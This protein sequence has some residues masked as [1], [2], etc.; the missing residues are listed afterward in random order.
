MSASETSSSQRQSLREWSTVVLEGPSNHDEERLKLMSVDDEK[1]S[2]G[3]AVEEKSGGSIIAGIS[4]EPFVAITVPHFL[5]NS[6]VERT[7]L[8]K[9]EYPRRLVVEETESS[10]Y[11]R[12][13]T[14]ESSAKTLTSLLSHTDNMLTTII[15][16]YSLS[17]D[18]FPSYNKGNEVGVNMLEEH[19]SSDAENAT[20]LSSKLSSSS[21]GFYKCESVSDEEVQPAFPSSQLSGAYPQSNGTDNAESSLER[22]KIQL[23]LKDDSRIHGVDAMQ[24]LR[25]DYEEDYE[26][27]YSPRKLQLKEEEH[28]RTSDD[29]GIVDTENQSKKAIILKCPELSQIRDAIEHSISTT[30]NSTITQALKKLAENAPEHTSL[31]NLIT[32]KAE[33]SLSTLQPSNDFTSQETQASSS[34]S[35]QLHNNCSSAT[36]S[37]MSKESA[38]LHLQNVVALK[39]PDS[40]GTDKSEIREN[41]A[42]LSKLANMQEASARD[43][44]NETESETF[45]NDHLITTEAMLAPNNASRSVNLQTEDNVHTMTRQHESEVVQTDSGLLPEVDVLKRRLLIACK[46]VQNAVK[47]MWLLLK[48]IYILL[49]IIFMASGQAARLFAMILFFVQ[50]IYQLIISQRKHSCTADFERKE[51]CNEVVASPL[52]DSSLEEASSISASRKMDELTDDE[53]VQ[54]YFHETKLPNTRNSDL[55]SEH[56]FP[57]STINDVYRSVTSGDALKEESNAFSATTFG[58]M[59]EASAELNVQNKVELNLPDSLG[60]DKSETREDVAELLNLIN[61]QDGTACG[62]ESTGNITGNKTNVSAEES[63]SRLSF[64]SMEDGKIAS[65]VRTERSFLEPLF[66]S[67]F[68]NISSCIESYLQSSSSKKTGKYLFTNFEHGFTPSN[69]EKTSSNSKI[70]YADSAQ[71]YVD[72]THWSEYSNSN[73]SIGEQI[74]EHRLKTETVRDMPKCLSDEVPNEEKCAVIMQATSLK[75]ESMVQKGGQTSQNACS[76]IS[77]AFQTQ[78]PTSMGEDLINNETGEILYFP[79]ISE[80]K[81]KWDSFNNSDGI[82]GVS[83]PLQPDSE[84]LLQD[85]KILGMDESPGRQKLQMSQGELLVNSSVRENEFDDS[86]NLSGCN[87]EWINVEFRKHALLH[88]NPRNKTGK[89]VTLLGNTASVTASPPYSFERKMSSRMIDCELTPSF[90]SQNETSNFGMLYSPGRLK[91]A[92]ENKRRTLKCRKYYFPNLSASADCLH[93]QQGHNIGLKKRSLAAKKRRNRK[94]VLHLSLEHQSRNWSEILTSPEQGHNRSIDNM[95]QT[96]TDERPAYTRESSQG[97][98]PYRETRAS[99]LRKAN[100]KEKLKL[101]K[102]L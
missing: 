39:V 94:K 27:E 8:T 70:S 62:H 43:H 87:V 97:A 4:S 32:G 64:L 75:E 88:E 72:L 65:P 40:W 20:D 60:T 15:S 85:K 95:A 38:Q 42:G 55:C 51:D 16:T 41:V 74:E 26:S 77:G 66:Q 101:R 84:L 91:K 1:L 73:N 100:I 93:R 71:S 44:E 86:F 82:L 23:S 17:A 14:S 56:T 54:D 63:P 80:R 45:S 28:T 33:I 35:V 68:E 47:I 5:G 69:L 29:F 53:K 21:Y 78:T 13:V 61:K 2:Q 19:L 81:E 58:I 46:T 31:T 49:K 76:L 30:S 57:E 3:N 102:S 12:V 9:S 59:C 98:T 22:G 18:N 10:S 89:T 25:T 99:M 34:D 96:R 92:S 7:T 24:N 50:I 67:N 52:H 79:S 48:G 83:T 11:P 37:A 90:G 36:F 6:L